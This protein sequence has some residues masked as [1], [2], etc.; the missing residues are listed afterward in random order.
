MKREIVIRENIP[1]YMNEL[2]QWLREIQD[3]PLEG[4][5]DFFRAR[6]GEYEDHMQLWAGAY[7]R[8]AEL[9]PDG[10]RTL[11]DLGCGTG[12]ELDAIFSWRRDISVTG[13]DL[14]PEMLERLRKKHPQVRTVCGDYFR[15]ELG[16]AQYDC[17][18]SFE[19]LHHFTGEKKWGLYE[20]IH[21][22]LKPGGVFFLVDYLACC[23]EEERLLMDF[24]REKRRAQ[25]IPENVF[26]H[27]DTPLTVEHETELLKCAGFSAV[28]L[29][30]CIAGASFVRCENRFTF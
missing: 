12:L 14:C 16:E 5:S 3:Q 30:D 2:K 13:V 22:A 10:A 26:V 20:K 19:S 23:A 1:A 6:L 8:L 21:R 27:F 11:L 15:T 28:E 24:C 18:V 9:I 17:A 29:I 7:G 25:N 4:M